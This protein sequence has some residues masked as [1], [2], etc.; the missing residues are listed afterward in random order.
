[1]KSKTTIVWFLFAVILAGAIWLSD[2]FFQPATL[3]EQPLFPGL[4]ANQVTGIQI[5]PAGGRAIN[6][7][8]T[9]HAWLLETPIAYP[10]QAAAIDGLLAALEKLT[11]VMT[12]S[13][14]EMS[15]RK[16]ADAE[17]GFTD[18]QYQLEVAGGAQTWRLVVGNKTAP[19]D[20]VYVRVKGA[21]GAQVTDTAWLQFLPH[22]ASDWRD[23]TLV[24][25]PAALDWLVVTNGTQA[26]ELRRDPA[27]HLWR[28]VRPLQ[29]RANNLSIAT[30]LQQLRAASVSRFIS[31]DPKADLSP[32]GLDAPTLGISLGCGTN[33][34]TAIY[35]GGD[36]TGAPGELY[37][38]RQGWNTVVSTAKAP[39]AS[40]RG[41][42]NDFRN[43]NLLELTAP[44]AEVEVDGD[45]GNFILQRSGSNT[46]SLAG[47]KFAVDGSQVA[48]FIKTLA[49]L[50]IVDFVQDVVTP[51]G[52]QNFG[53]ARPSQQITLRS[54]V[55]DTNK[56]IAQLLFG[57]STTNGIIYV[58]RGDEDFVY[59]LS[60]ANLN[61]L[62]VPG[63]FYRD[64]RVWSFSETN[65]ASVTLRQSGKIRQLIR[66]GTNDWSL[67]AGS[68]GIINPPAVEEAIHRLG[69]L[70]ALA[71]IG[72]KFTNADVGLTTNSLSVTIE[73][74]SGEK[75][76]VD[77]GKEVRV[78]S[79]N[80]S[81]ALATV[82]L[83]GQ[84]WALVFPPVL[85]PLVAE[86]LTIPDAQ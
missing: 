63:D 28:M 66:T 32:Y 46:W 23:T 4:L 10:A 36:V 59:A 22:D 20:G 73:L 68:Q 50:R 33:L 24:E 14:A 27:S 1:M 21:D 54:A 9:N 48:A 55:G 30:A 13:A 35:A 77:F 7:G 25:V 81:T 72:R 56:V 16:N 37:A 42:V 44:V 70:T 18:P 60:L 43:P 19:G 58:K 64:H 29:T 47:E 38:R 76:A 52:W 78:P 34:V 26:I 83:E 40:W 49:G 5:I 85:C 39:L 62:S 74:K 2:K 79:L 41:A 11:P 65:V 17:F 51:S 12:I 75:Y 6:V 3:A 57:A 82:T 69:S 71:W 84:R 8:R 53:L 45:N 67:A 86:Y 15:G 31:D 80:A 61:Q